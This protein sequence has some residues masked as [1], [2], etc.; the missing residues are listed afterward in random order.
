MVI[1]IITNIIHHLKQIHHGRVKHCLLLGLLNFLKLY[2]FFHVKL[3][4]NKKQMFNYVVCTERRIT[5]YRVYTQV[6]NRL[7]SHI[8]ANRWWRV[9]HS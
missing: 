8:E 9:L 2:I 1:I 4:P 5:A 3:S 7:V 6:Y